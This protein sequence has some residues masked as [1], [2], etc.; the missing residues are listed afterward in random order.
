VAPQIQSPLFLALPSVVPQAGS[1]LHLDVLSEVDQAKEAWQYSLVLQSGPVAE[2]L[3]ASAHMQKSFAVTIAAVA[4]PPHFVGALQRAS[5]F[6]VA[7]SR[8]QLLASQF[9]ASASVPHLQASSFF[10]SPPLF[11]HRLTLWA[12]QVPVA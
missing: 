9:G 8:H 2:S 5:L 10:V 11:V 1:A 6:F 3:A 12:V 7:P 4:V